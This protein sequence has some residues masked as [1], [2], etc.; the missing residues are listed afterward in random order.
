MKWIKGAKWRKWDLHVHSPASHNFKGDWNQFIIQ[1]GNAD[2]DVIGPGWNLTTAMADDAIEWLNQLNQIAPDKPF[3]FSSAVS[4]SH[5][6]NR[7][8]V[9]EQV[10][11]PLAGVAAAESV[12][13]LEP[14]A[15]R[16]LV[17]GPSLARRKGR[18]IMVL[19]EPRSGVGRRDRSPTRHLLQPE[20]F[21][22]LALRAKRP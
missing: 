18:R 1:L 11:L 3:F 20:P 4:P 5:S 21:G 9:T 19:A 16:P 13:I 22:L 6:L 17:E 14:H 7:C 10:R 15:D 12:E 2:C 8:G